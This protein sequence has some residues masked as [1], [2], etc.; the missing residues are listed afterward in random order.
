MSANFK[1]KQTAAYTLRLN[2]ITAASRG[3]LATAL[4]SCYSSRWLLLVGG[5]A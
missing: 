1:P 3:L 5:V 2:L 4:L